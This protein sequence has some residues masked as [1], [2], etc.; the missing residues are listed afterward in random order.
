MTLT[1]D[2][3]SGL[4][5]LVIGLVVVVDAQSHAMGTLLRMGPGYYPTLVGSLIVLVGGTLVVK[6]WL[7]GGTPVPVIAWRAMALLTTGI[8]VFALTLDRLG[9]VI[10]TVLLIFISRLASRPFK[11]VSTAVLAAAM[12]VLAALVFWW[13]LRLPVELWP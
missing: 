2:L 6:S 10:S 7:Q 12:A 1:K 5:F 3:V 11:P 8:V 13:F 4:L 9:L